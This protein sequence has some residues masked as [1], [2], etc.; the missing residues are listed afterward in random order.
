[1]Q[2]TLLVLRTQVRRNVSI[3]CMAFLV[4][5]LKKETTLA[6]CIKCLPDTVTLN[7]MFVKHIPLKIYHH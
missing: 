3:K 6:L 1:M 7:M 2:S 5:K 4:Q